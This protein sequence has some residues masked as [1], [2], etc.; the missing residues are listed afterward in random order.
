MN[1][2]EFED[3][4]KLFHVGDCMRLICRGNYGDYVEVGRLIKVEKGRVYLDKGFSHSYRRIKR[5][6]ICLENDER[7]IK[8]CG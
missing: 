7:S 5:I 8:K 3:R 6:E 4:I 2:F 1:R